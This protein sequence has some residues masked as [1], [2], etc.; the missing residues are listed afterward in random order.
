MKTSAQRK[1]VECRN[2]NAHSSF[3]LIL[4]NRNSY[5]VLLI[6]VRNE[7]LLFSHKQTDAFAEKIY[8]NT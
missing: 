8:V 1:N 4:E 2:D 5:V 7:Y 6:Y 3:E